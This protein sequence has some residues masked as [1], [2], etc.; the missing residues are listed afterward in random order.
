MQ[1]S[2]RSSLRKTGCD[3]YFGRMSGDGIKKKRIELTISAE[4]LRTLGEIQARAEATSSAGQIR[5][6]LR[7]ERLNTLMNAEKPLTILTG[8]GQLFAKLL[9]VNQK[10]FRE[11]LD[12]NA[13][14]ESLQSQLTH[15]SVSLDAYRR[16]I[17]DLQSSLNKANLELGDIDPITR[18]RR[19]FSKL[20][21][22]TFS[23]R[24]GFVSVNVQKFI[25]LLRFIYGRPG[26]KS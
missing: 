9:D 14:I 15:N 5:A 3:H 19:T 6:I 20:L 8:D 11:W 22:E 7:Q 25:Q 12:R 2:G 18:N 23:I 26:R 10:W 17:S 4:A 21:Q 24:V 13:I 16:V 1:I